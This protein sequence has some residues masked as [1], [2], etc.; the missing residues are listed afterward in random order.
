MRMYDDPICVL[1]DERPR[2]FIWRDRLLLIKKIQSRWVR[3]VAWWESE[4]IRAARGEE[5]VE[6][7]G[8]L[9]IER[10]VF[11]V[12]A[13]NGV[14]RGVYELAHTLGAEDWILQAVLD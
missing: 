1:F 12:E 2:Q 10:E 14:H 9:N 5:V 7:S 4:T 8:E 6:G 11:R 3:A 13:G